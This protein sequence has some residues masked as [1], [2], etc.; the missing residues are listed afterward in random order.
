VPTG[1]PVWLEELALPQ[2]FTPPNSSASAITR[3]APYV[4]RVRPGFREAKRPH[5]EPS[6]S[7]FHYI[8]FNTALIDSVTFPSFPV[9]VNVS[10]PFCVAGVEFP[11]LLE[12][13]HAAI[14]APQSTTSNRK[15]HAAIARRLCAAARL[16]HR[17]SRSIV[18]INDKGSHLRSPSSGN[19]S[20]R[21]G[22]A[23]AVVVIV[24]MTG[25]VCGVPF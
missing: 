16:I 3:P 10:C 5:A 21:S 23:P 9:I 13:L 17:P 4:S 1:V 2:P 14:H 24:T 7:S 11:P 22:N 20:R 25:T 6:Q 18:A 8:T 12:E 19:F 15:T